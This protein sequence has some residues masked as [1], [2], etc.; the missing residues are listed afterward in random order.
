MTSALQAPWS[1]Q[2][3]AV[4]NP[5]SPCGI[6][7][8]ISG[9]TGGAE[10][11]N[12]LVVFVQDILSARKYFPGLVE[13]ILGIEIDTGIGIYLAGLAGTAEALGNG[14]NAGFDQPL[15]RRRDADR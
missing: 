7:S 11:E 5:A 13:L 3:H 10:V 6:E 1:Q 15:L 14:E 4:G 8:R 9:G 12:L 2:S